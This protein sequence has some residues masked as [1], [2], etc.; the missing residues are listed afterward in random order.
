VHVTDRGRRVP[1]LKPHPA[2]RDLL[3]ARRVDHFASGSNALERLRREEVQGAV[4][5]VHRG[6]RVKGRVGRN[7]REVV[8]MAAEKT[9]RPGHWTE[10]IDKRI[11]R[12]EHALEHPKEH[13]YRHTGEVKKARKELAVLHRARDAS[14]EQQT[15]VF[16]AA[17]HLVALRRAQ[18]VEEV[19]LGTL[20]PEQARRAA[21]G[22]YAVSHMGARHFSVEEHAAMESAARRQERVARAKVDAAP[23]GSADRA[24]ALG[25][26]RVAR[27]HRIAVS[28]REPGGVR[29]HEDLQ[30]QATRAEAVHERARTRVRKLENERNRLTGRQQVQR[31]PDAARKMQAVAG[32]PTR[33]RAVLA[34]IDEAMNRNERRLRTGASKEQLRERVAAKLD[35][36]LV[37]ARE[38]EK[39]TRKAAR[40]A[41]AMADA[42]KLPDTQA[43]IRT[44]EGHH[45]PNS[46]IEEHMRASGVDP[47]AVAQLTHR[48]LGK[49]A[50][51]K[52]LDVSTRP[53]TPQQRRTLHAFERG[54]SGHG[55]LQVEESA[56]NAAT[57]ISKAQSV[58]RFIH[59][60]GLL[61]PDGRGWTSHE[62][63]ALVDATQ[64][65]RMVRHL[66]PAGEVERLLQMLNRPFRFSV[67]AQPRWLTGNF[68]EPYLCGC[69][70]SGRVGEHVRA[71]AGH[72]GV[73]GRS[74][75]M[76]RS[77]DPAG[78]RRPRGSGRSST[79][80]CSSA[81]VARATGGARGLELAGD[82]SRRRAIRELPVV[83]QLG[84]C[85][86]V[87]RRVLPGEPSA[88]RAVGAARGV[89]HQVRATSRRSRGRGRR[90][91]C[92]AQ[93]ARGGP[94]RPD[95]Y[96]TQ[97]RFMRAQ[98]E[99]LGKYE[100][101]SPTMRRL[102]QT[103]AP[104]LPWAL[105]AARFVF[106]TMPVHH[107]ILTTA[108]AEDGGGR[109]QGVEGRAQGCAGVEVPGATGGR[110]DEG[111]RVRAGDPVH[112]V[113]AD[114][115]DRARA[116]CRASRTS[117][118]R[119]CRGRRRRS[120]QGPVRAT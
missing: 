54:V 21:L 119:S 13:G 101:Y 67:L 84:I 7:A 16:A 78:A 43:A 102:I 28:G 32:Q 115:P 79:A 117:S 38:R 114:R 120:G 89:R 80:A 51:H 18:D 30:R 103:V 46:A 4:H 96:A 97:E 81:A 58:D 109:R 92:W 73:A 17:D 110:A 14:P 95:R 118:C 27:E 1:V 3:H 94:A 47:E 19:R 83:K 12:L 57:R 29:R 63:V 2:E 20:N 76:E 31:G 88:D 66:A 41:R 60:H 108:A 52:R 48:E 64:I 105:S 26:Y 25:E 75:A 45:L 53:R 6:G 106:W 68:V 5:D 111:R 77:G 40:E 116:I 59:D 36:Q 34:H 69:R 37:A 93:G 8:S 33:A 113:R 100:G 50:F 86:G 23:A 70:R 61:H 35:K 10:D 74:S 55:H 49:G 90:R 91:C 62:A 65:N 39:A 24:R 85:V 104:F 98:H 42:S 82:A 107:T 72:R 112:A 87:C 71:G 56:V 44:A 15:R 99:L 11:G 22:P 9:I